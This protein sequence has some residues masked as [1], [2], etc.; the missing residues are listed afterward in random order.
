VAHQW[1]R[2]FAPLPAQRLICNLKASESSSPAQR[3]DQIGRER[4]GDT[5][6]RHYIRCRATR[7][8][9]SSDD[10]GG[11]FGSPGPTRKVAAAGAGGRGG[12][13]AEPT[14][15]AYLTTTSRRQQMSRFAFPVHGPI[16]TLF[17]QRNNGTFR[18][19]NKRSVGNC[20]ASRCRAVT[21]ARGFALAPLAKR[22]FSPTTW[23]SS[24]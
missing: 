5:G 23:F 15:W 13:R 7:C 9:F 12:S 14:G 11:E 6:A 10:S 4:G 22:Q 24:M 21:T 1:P 3:L 18:P 2:V 20:G 8:D 17:M 16:P 19:A